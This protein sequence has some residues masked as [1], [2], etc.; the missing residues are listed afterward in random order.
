MATSAPSFP[1]AY[2]FIAAQDELSDVE[3]RRARHV[4]NEISRTEE[5]VNVLRKD[6]P[7][8]NAFGQFVNSSHESLR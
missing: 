3:F 4:I 1:V 8:Y 2:H 5:A 7:D 6:P